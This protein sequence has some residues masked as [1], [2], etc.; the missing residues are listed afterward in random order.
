MG[1]RNSRFGAN[2]RCWFSHRCSG[3]P[4]S[5]WRR[6]IRRGTCRKR[7][8]Q[9]P[10]NTHDR[11][12]FGIAGPSERLVQTL[13]V[14]AG[15]LRNLAHAACT[16]NETKR[17]AHEIRVPGFE[18]RR[19]I[20]NLTLLGVEILRGIKSRRL[21]RRLGHHNISVSASRDLQRRNFPDLLA[22]F[23]LRLMQVVALLQIEP[24]I[25][26]VSA[27]FPES[28]CHRWRYR[29]PFF[30]DIVERLARYAEQLGDLR[31]GPIERG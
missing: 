31:L 19:D 3:D 10:N 21:W 12:E 8:A 1:T 11:A 2:A 7:Q 16:C 22:E 4:A 17:V 15:L 18:R 29:L 25:G 27:Q 13:A 14:Q 30:Q 26:S 6:C 23:L 5:F 20:S 9:G 24:E 28:Q